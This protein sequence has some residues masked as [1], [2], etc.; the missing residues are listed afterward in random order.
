MFR[1][2]I[3]LLTNVANRLYNSNHLYNPR[4]YSNKYNDHPYK[5]NKNIRT[6]IGGVLII[7]T[8]IGI[9]GW[10]KVLPKNF[11]RQYNSTCVD[12]LVKINL[13]NH[14]YIHNKE[15]QL[16]AVAYN[17]ILLKYINP[18]FMNTDVLDIA[19][20]TVGV[21]SKI[22][23][24]TEE[25]G[26]YKFRENHLCILDYGIALIQNLDVVDYKG[27]HSITK[28]ELIHLINIYC[29]ANN[30]DNDIKQSW[31]NYAN[32]ATYQN[33]FVSKNMCIINNFSRVIY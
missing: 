25:N 22:D 21:K 9:Y 6:C 7:G 30:I 17:P 29:E 32:T 12:Y 23:R 24:Y 26:A 3:N 28:D 4:L 16:E 20:H 13:D 8:A 19:I 33:K 1:T 11:L 14:N 18:T 27:M 31:L 15:L 10:K 5:S 2:Q